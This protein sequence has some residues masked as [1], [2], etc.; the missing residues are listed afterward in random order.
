LGYYG[1]LCMKVRGL[2]QTVFTS[3]HVMTEI[4]GVM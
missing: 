3:A 2:P 4:G 1:S